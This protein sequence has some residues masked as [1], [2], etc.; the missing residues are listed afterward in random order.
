MNVRHVEI[1]LALM[2]TRSVTRASE[3][4]R[5]S[6]PA[7]SKALRLLEAELGL[8]LFQRSSKGLVPT[9]EA[10]ALYAE[11]ER[12]FAGIVSMERFARSLGRMGHSRLVVATIP[13]LSL[14]WMP[15]VAGEFTRLY[16]DASLKFVAASSPATMQLV[17]NGEVDVGISQ[18]LIE[19]PS[20]NRRKLFDLEGLIVM[21]RTHP[22]AARDRLRIQDLNGERMISLSDGDHLRRVLEGRMSDARVNVISRLEVA[23][24]AM[25][26]SL[27]R[28]GGTLG[29]VDSATARSQPHDDLV[30][31]P[32]SPALLVPIYLLRNS[33]RSADLIMQNFTKLILSRAP[34][35]FVPDR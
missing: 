34:A 26:C 11:A 23:L 31:R 24:G 21:P 9:Q 1:F 35:K 2:E 16:P 15:C 4:L 25:V 28:S 33:R 27:V 7:V 3:A 8:S 32:L 18:T 5:L 30:Y 19:D 13:A 6:Q 17:A 20:V 29:I 10:R 12:A 14:G 22:L